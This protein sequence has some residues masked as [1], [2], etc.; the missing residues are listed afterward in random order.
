MVADQETEK[1]LT[2]KSKI[3]PRKR[4]DAEEIGKAPSRK[5]QNLSPQRTQRAL[6]KSEGK[7]LPLINADDRGSGKPKKLYRRG[8]G[9]IQR[10]SGE[11]LTT[12]K[13]R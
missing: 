4:G 8:H 2:T 7:T 13:H 3:A 6:R 11:N 5:E 12:D 10:E 9:G 1:P